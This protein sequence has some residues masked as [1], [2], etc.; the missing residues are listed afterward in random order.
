LYTTLPKDR[1][2]EVKVVVSPYERET[3]LIALL[4]WDYRLEMDS[5]DRAA[6]ESFYK[7]HVDK[8]P[9]QVP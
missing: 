7:A 4:A 1:F 8:G 6:I 5:F 2:N 3:H 9:E